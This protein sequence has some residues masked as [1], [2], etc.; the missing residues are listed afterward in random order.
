MRGTNKHRNGN[1]RAYLPPR[2]HELEHSVGE[3][4]DAAEHLLLVEL[5]ELVVVV[6]GAHVDHAVHV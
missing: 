4:E 5:D 6:V 3:D 2:P 1:T